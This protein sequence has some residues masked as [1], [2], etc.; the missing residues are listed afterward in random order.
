MHLTRYLAHF[1]HDFRFTHSR[2]IVQGS[3]N[4][5]PLAT[6]FAKF[7]SAL[8]NIQCDIEGAAVDIDNPLLA[9]L[10]HRFSDGLCAIWDVWQSLEVEPGDVGVI[11]Q[12]V[13]RRRPMFRKF[14][15]VAKEIAI[16]YVV[17]ADLRYAPKDVEWL[18]DVM[19]VGSIR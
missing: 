18:T 17:T 4:D 12:G 11:I 5:G 14:T 3:S 6:L 15:N 9:S 8:E 2:N 1:A 10:Q 16:P 7:S 13:D 19:P